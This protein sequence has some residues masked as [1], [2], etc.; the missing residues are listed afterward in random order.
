LQ[1]SPRCVH[2]LHLVAFDRVLIS[3]PIAELSLFVAILALL[4]VLF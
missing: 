4:I 2:F 3:P 1:S